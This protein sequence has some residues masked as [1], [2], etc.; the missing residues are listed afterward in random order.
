MGCA[1]ARPS[2]HD[3]DGLAT[4]TRDQ[5]AVALVLGTSN[6]TLAP[7]SSNQ[8]TGTSAAKDRGETVPY[9]ATLDSYA[10][11]GTRSAWFTT[12]VRRNIHTV[13]VQA[14]SN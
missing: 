12:S 14:E 3:D 5:P 4:R 10:G 1:V 8:H 11:S 6:T 2:A 13:R 7:Y 9:T